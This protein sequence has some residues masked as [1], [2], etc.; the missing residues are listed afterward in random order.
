MSLQLSA[1]HFG[2][3]PSSNQG[4]YWLD[5]FDCENLGCKNIEQLYNYTIFSSG[6]SSV[7]VQQRHVKFF[8]W[9]AFE[10]IHFVISM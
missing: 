10:I 1:R 3:Y 9:E 4:F 2:K 6:L 8:D 5:I 7:Q